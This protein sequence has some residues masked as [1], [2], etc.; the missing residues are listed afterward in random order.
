[1]FALLLAAAPIGLIAAQA[2]QQPSIFDKAINN[3]GLGWEVYGPNQK[4][5]EVPA[6]EVP[7]GN[8]VRVQV[9]KAGANP[10]DAGANYPAVKP[11]AAGDT[12]LVMVF[13]RAPDV[14]AGSTVPIPISAGATEPPYTA[15]ATE[16]VQVG[17]TWKRYYASG[18]AKE[19][20][21]AGK[22]RMSVQLAGAKQVIE[23]G[24]AFLLNLGQGV[25]PATL[26]KN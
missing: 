15:V 10:W 18:V 26:P 24:P 25:D 8:A 17:P 9:A 22:A 5:K 23:M 6:A 1:M 16:T 11:V 2:P 7:G 21:A 20:H 4:A 3:P 12:L 19:A 13:L 14:P